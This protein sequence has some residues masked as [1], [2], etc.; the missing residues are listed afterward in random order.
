MDRGSK[1]LL[2]LHSETIRSG[3]NKMEERSPIIV[4]AERSRMESGM[5][6]MASMSY[7]VLD[8]IVAGVLF[9]RTPQCRRS[10]G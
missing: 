7:P 10:A 1:R 2:S 6:L 3:P 5:R 8:P 9:P 4:P